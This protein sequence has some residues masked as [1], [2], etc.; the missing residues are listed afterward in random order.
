[1]K[2]GGNHVDNLLSDP[3]RSLLSMAFPL[4]LAILVE[5]LQTFVDGMWCSG[6]GSE[7]L[8]AISISSCI[9]SMIVALGTGMAVGASASIA[10]SIGAGDRRSAENAIPSIILIIL[11]MSVLTSIA[12]WFLAEPIVSF[13]GQGQN[14]EA[15][16]EYTRPF[17]IMSFFLMMNSVW[18]G[19]LRAEGASLVCMG[20]SILASAINIV[21]DPLFIYGLD[22]GLEGASIATCLSYVAVTVVGFWYYLS[23]RTYVKMRFRGFRPDRAVNRDLVTVGGPCALEMFVAPLLMIPQNA[24]VFSC[25]GNTG[26]VAYTYAFKFIDM[27]LIPANAISK[28]LIPIIS[29]DIGQNS[30]EKVLESCRIAYRITLGIGF[31]CM[32][33][34]F[35]FADILVGLFMNSESMEAVRGQMTLALR[36]F[37]LTCVFH[38]FRLVGTSILQ[39]TRH[40]MLSSVLTLARELLFLGTFYIASFYSM[41]AIFWACDVTNFTMMFVISVFAYHAVRSLVKEMGGGDIRVGSMISLRKG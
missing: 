37:T 25:G 17:L 30:P 15:C 26:M 38:T 8:S 23:G 29:A 20:M 32:V 24:I 10:R 39:A 31:V 16:M 11:A 36:I 2:N 4:F 27:A 34:I 19:I 14:V 12:F 35:I 5:N 22:M 1:M 28:S 3:R 13:V 9:Y 21:L 41:E 40:A 7:A 18:V 33:S 6:L